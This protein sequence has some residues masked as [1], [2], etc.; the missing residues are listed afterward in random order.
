MKAASCPQKILAVSGTGDRIYEQ[1]DRILGEDEPCC[2]GLGVR[3]GC[4]RSHQTPHLDAIGS[5]KDYD[6]QQPHAVKRVETSEQ[7]SSLLPKLCILG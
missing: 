5:K 6:T 7:A 1:I 4:N 3:V 2:Y